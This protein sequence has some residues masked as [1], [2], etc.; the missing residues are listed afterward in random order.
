MQKHSAHLLVCKDGARAGIVSCPTTS[1][2]IVQVNIPAG[3]AARSH[4]IPIIVIPM[5]YVCCP[6][7]L[8]AKKNDDRV[9]SWPLKKKA[10][11][12]DISLG[13]QK[14]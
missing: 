13:R 2:K 8:K 4:F 3:P 10:F 12:Q 7:I 9:K 11:L 1:P 6:A 14:Y 5:H